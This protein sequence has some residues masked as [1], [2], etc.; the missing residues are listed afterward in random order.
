MGHPRREL[1]CYRALYDVLAAEFANGGAQPAPSRPPRTAHPPRDGASAVVTCFNLSDEDTLRRVRI[2]P[3]DVGLR[4]DIAFSIVGAALRLQNDEYV[5][6]VHIPAHGHQ[7][8][9]IRRSDNPPRMAG[10]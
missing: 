5:G 10:Q 9:E 1:C 4:D 7:L 6:D 3:R 8:L 2:R